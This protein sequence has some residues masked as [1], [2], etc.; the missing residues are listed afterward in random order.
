MV[1]ESLHCSL[2]DII[3]ILINNLSYY[4]LKDSWNNENTLA[5]KYV[6]GI[7]GR[8]TFNIGNTE[9]KI[10]CHNEYV[11]FEFSNKKYAWGFKPS[12]MKSDSMKGF[13]LMNNKMVD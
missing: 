10:D 7:C 13:Q 4:V 2:F 11:K 12:D 9:G 1:L 3:L 6:Q 5:L 8:L